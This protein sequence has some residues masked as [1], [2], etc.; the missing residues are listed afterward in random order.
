MK[1]LT[2]DFFLSIYANTEYKTRVLNAKI[3]CHLAPHEDGEVPH[4]RWTTFS[5]GFGRERKT[6]RFLDIKGEREKRLI[7]EIVD[8][9]IW[10]IQ[11]G[12]LVVCEK[13]H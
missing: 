10:D 8:S 5:H 13:S 11:E 7:Y 3:L 4:H 9:E 1:I 2:K 12:V 6:L